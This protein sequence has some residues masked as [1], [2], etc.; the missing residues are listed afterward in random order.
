MVVRSPYFVS[1]KRYAVKFVTVPYCYGTVSLYS[2]CM[3]NIT[4]HLLKNT[5]F[6][7]ENGKKIFEKLPLCPLFR[8][9]PEI[10][11]SVD[12]FSGDN[13]LLRDTS[14]CYKNVEVRSCLNSIN[15][16]L[17]IG[18]LDTL[19]DLWRVRALSIFYGSFGGS[20]FRI[21]WF[22]DIILSFGPL[23]TPYKILLYLWGSYN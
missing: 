13:L 2:F 7:Y 4:S 17:L 6:L 20:E 19:S 12:N 8:C 21:F 15:I 5:S 14:Y 3:R 16:I 11:R 23:F 22:N 9:A 1:I 10:I 18:F